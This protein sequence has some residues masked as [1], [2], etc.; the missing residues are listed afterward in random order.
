MNFRQRISW[1][2]VI[3][4]LAATMGIMYYVFE[5]SE[6]FNQYALDH[7]SRY[8]QGQAHTGWHIAD[9]P[10]PVIMLIVILPYLQVGRLAYL[11]F[12]NVLIAMISSV[13]R[14]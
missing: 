1:L 10:L 3:C 9:I 14:V 7:I 13:R 2:L 4:Y 11:K 5:I 8:S 12:G 6:R